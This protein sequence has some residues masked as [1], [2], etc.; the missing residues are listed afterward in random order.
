MGMN[1]SGM[2]DTTG[3]TTANGTATKKR[4]S[5]R[6]HEHEGASLASRVVGKIDP[7]A[8]VDGARRLPAIIQQQVKEN[9]YRALGIAAGVGFGVG[10][11]F[12]SRI[13]RVLLVTAGGYAVN[14]F[15]R[16]RI[17]AFLEDLEGNEG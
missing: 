16:G 12:S 11:M 2:N 6:G 10:A 4:G 3:P 8:I 7:E 1:T 17:K 13:A 9:P 14:E 5:H 15:A